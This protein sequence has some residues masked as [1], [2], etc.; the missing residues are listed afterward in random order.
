MEQEGPKVR[1]LKAGEEDA[2]QR[3]DNFLFRTL[4]GV[5]KS[6]V[7]RLLRTGQVRVNKRR[8]KPDYRLEAGDELRL[9]PV[10]QEAKAAPGLSPHW[11]QEA[12]K[13]SIIFEDD[14]LLV[15]NKPAGMAV[16]GGSGVSFG[17][18]ETLRVL[19]PESPSIELAHRLDRET[20]GCLIVAKRRSMVRVLH[21]AF[22]E[23]R[24]E[25]RYLALLAH[26]WTGGEQTVDLPLEKNLLQGGERMVKVSREGKEAKSLFRPMQKFADSA[27][28]EIRIFTG[29][30]HQIRVHA[31][32]IG[33]PVA[34]DEK[35]GEKEANKG[36]KAVGLKRMF[37]HAAELA[38]EHPETGE[39]LA[40]K[41]PLDDELE[42]VLLNLGRS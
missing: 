16:H 20:S 25:K 17:V 33:H 39:R 8:A 13:T 4:K 37:L 22:R 23:G 10:R 30:T 40:L 27:L 18:I 35:Y 1:L 26:A 34:G 24:V 29:R 7:Y 14:R 21:A 11:Q 9:P 41:A 38:F 6:H 2:G 19:R 5:P 36:F 31:A 12:L 32:H 28:L 42:A 3:L 15:I